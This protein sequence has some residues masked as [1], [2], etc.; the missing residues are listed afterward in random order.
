MTR[1]LVAMK[2]TFVRWFTDFKSN[3]TSHSCVVG[4]SCT[5]VMPV[6][7]VADL[8]A[9]SV[10]RRN[11]G[12]RAVTPVNGFADRGTISATHRMASPVSTPVERP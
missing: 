8:M 7:W 1:W 6:Q 10:T 9:I 3:L 12:T 11:G 5:A 4:Y 2:V